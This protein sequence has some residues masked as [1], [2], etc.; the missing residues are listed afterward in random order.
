MG[1]GPT[2]AF[3]ILRKQ[4]DDPPEE[5]SLKVQ[6]TETLLPTPVQLPAAAGL[7][8]THL[9]VLRDTTLP[10]FKMGPEVQLPTVRKHKKGKHTV[11]LHTKIRP[12]SFL[13][14]NERPIALF[15]CLSGETR[16]REGTKK[17]T[18]KLQRKT[19]ARSLNGPPTQISSAAPPHD[20]AVRGVFLLFFG[21]MVA[22]LKLDSAPVRAGRGSFFS[23]LCS[24]IVE[25]VYVC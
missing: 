24:C 15:V 13:A 19:E 1:V 8:A 20:L 16:V 11:T 25:Y 4:R 10:N 6:T 9:S 3:H 12:T 5:G 7:M 18:E 17:W 23:R 22:W 14:R 2:C 21:T